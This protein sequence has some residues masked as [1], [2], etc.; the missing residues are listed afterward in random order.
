MFYVKRYLCSH[1][2]D[3]KDQGE[4]QG[5]IIRLEW[6]YSKKPTN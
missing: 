3:K 1:L 5:P 2:R 6:V 4:D